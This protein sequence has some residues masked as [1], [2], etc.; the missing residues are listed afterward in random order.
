MRRHISSGKG[1]RNEK[2]SQ[3]FGFGITL[4]RRLAERSSSIASENPV[5]IYHFLKFQAKSSLMGKIIRQPLRSCSTY[6]PLTNFTNA[7]KLLIVV[8]ITS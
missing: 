5:P 4:E 2:K 7:L 3:T 1:R 6:Y 8:V